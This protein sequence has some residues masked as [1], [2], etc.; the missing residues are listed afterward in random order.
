MKRY[1]YTNYQKLLESF[2]FKLDSFNPHTEILNHY[3]EITENFD[4]INNPPER[5]EKRNY[6]LHCIV[7]ILQEYCRDNSAILE[8]DEKPVGITLN[9][10]TDNFIIIYSETN[11]KAII[12]YTTLFSI[13]NEMDKIVLE[14]YFCT[15]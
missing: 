15:K 3:F 6:I 14:F 7:P 1:D 2:D 5:E 4:P 9:I 12:Y 13:R 11:L 8:V 10:I